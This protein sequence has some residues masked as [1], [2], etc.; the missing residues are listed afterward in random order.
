MRK[1]GDLVT[2]NVLPSLGMG[3]VVEIKTH[4][5]STHNVTCLFIESGRRFTYFSDQLELVE[6]K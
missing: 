6:T 5:Y 3:V 4:N 2:C 1:V